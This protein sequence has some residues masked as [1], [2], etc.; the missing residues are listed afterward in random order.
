MDHFRRMAS[1]S[2][3]ALALLVAACGSDAADGG[4]GDVKNE[5]SPTVPGAR[6]V[7]VE[8]SNFAFAPDRITAAPGEQI[9]IEM[10]SVKDRHD[11][12][13]LGAE[14]LRVAWASEGQT[15]VGGLTAPT[16]PGVYRFICSEIGHLAEGMEGE[17]VVE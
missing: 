16:E 8:A 12:V 11:L 13:L 4:S 17:L 5:G 15:A 10:I 14:S 7:P 3:L 6:V 1:S 9:T 2:A